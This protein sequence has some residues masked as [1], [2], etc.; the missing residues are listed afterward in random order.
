MTD[1]GGLAE[2]YI[3]EISKL[4][5]SFLKGAEDLEAAIR[6]GTTTRAK[7][8]MVELERRANK[9]LDG[10]NQL[11]DTYEATS[12]HF[13]P[14][15]YTAEEEMKGVLRKH[16]NDGIK[17]FAQAVMDES[18]TPFSSTHELKVLETEIAQMSYQHKVNVGLIR[19]QMSGD[20]LYSH[21]RPILAQARASKAQLVMTQFLTKE[22]VRLCK[23]CV[24]PR[25]LDGAPALS[26]PGTP[27]S[28]TASLAENELK[29][30][31]ESST[32]LFE[33]SSKKSALGKGVKSSTSK[34]SSP[35]SK[36][37][38]THNLLGE[39]S[40][41]SKPDKPGAMPQTAKHDKPEK[42][43]KRRKH[44]KRDKDEKKGKHSKHDKHSKA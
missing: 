42:R 32:A 43:N 19:N 22:S 28:A 18:V 30:L 35:D 7:H 23:A 11:S 15:I 24:G 13:F 25:V 27:A 8:S 29:S 9:L 5:V 6:M 14:D 39:L 36:D 41:P 16:T 37:K 20:A 21:V 1:T 12:E 44:R 17:R 38:V 10:G 2:T 34:H 33:G 40:T 31:L 26:L 4:S 3:S